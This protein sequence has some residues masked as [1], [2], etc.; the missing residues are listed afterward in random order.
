MLSGRE[1]CILRQVDVDR[2][3]TRHRALDVAQNH[4]APLHDLNSVAEQTAG[5]FCVPRQSPHSVAAG[6]QASGYGVTQHPRC[7]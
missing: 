2:P 1:F 6:Q 7:P 5:A 3:T 4:R